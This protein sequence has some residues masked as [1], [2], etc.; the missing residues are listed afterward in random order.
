MQTILNVLHLV[1]HYPGVKAVDGITFF[2]E[3]GNIFGLLGPNGAGKTTTINIISQV[4]TADSGT[5]EV[6]GMDISSHSARVKEIVGL[7]TQ[8]LAIYPKLTGREN[9]NFFGGIYNLAGKELNDRI[10]ETLELVGLKDAAGRLAETY[11]GGMK[12]RLNI[13]A[14]MLNMP[15]LLILDEPA[16]GVDPQSRNHILESIRY[17]REQYGVSI[18]F[19]SHYM[20]EVHALCD[21]VAIIDHG[22]IIA[23]NTIDYL[24]EKFGQGSIHI[25]FEN[26]PGDVGGFLPGSVPAGSVR[27]DGTDLLV[28]TPNPHRTLPGVLEAL[29]ARDIKID[30]IE[31]YR[32]NLETV[33]LNLTGRSLRDE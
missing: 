23:D 5:I 2:I 17:I 30:S 22:K 18:L 28:G 29:N 1:K 16:V 4:L 24:I 9:L 15:R 32:S 26:D 10:E 21:R 3:K 7:V 33:F 8:D 20:E 14:G 6:D 27:Q 19:T 12:R 11:S 13:A 25:Q 31:I